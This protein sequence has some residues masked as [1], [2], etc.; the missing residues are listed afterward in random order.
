[1]IPLHLLIRAHLPAQD[2]QRLTY[3]SDGSKKAAMF[4]VVV[5]FLA[6]YFLFPVL[7]PMAVVALFLWFAVACG[8]LD[9]KLR[10]Q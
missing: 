7:P 3:D 4:W 10:G 2:V 9:G 5:A 1:M 6:S 8:A